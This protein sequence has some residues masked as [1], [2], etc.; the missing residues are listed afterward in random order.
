MK[1]FF[2][3]IRSVKTDSKIKILYVLL[4]LTLGISLGILSKWLDNLS[5]DSSVWWMNLIDRLDLR[6]F[7]SD[8]SIWLLIALTL[9]IYSKTPLRAS[10]NVFIFF[11]GMTI[12]YHLYTILFSGFNPKEYMMLWYGLTIISPLIAYICWYSKSDNKYSIIISSL[13]LFIM[14]ESC[15]NTG[16]LYFDFKGI[17]YTL[18]FIAS[19][20]VIYKKSSYLL[21][22]ILIGLTLSIFLRVPLISG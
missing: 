18:V 5:I 15:F 21:L 7:F 10:L 11:L 4:I 1:D 17:L 2:E 9:S 20:I 22:S 19:C 8:M 6:N 16:L 12:S 13:V 14:T 3:K